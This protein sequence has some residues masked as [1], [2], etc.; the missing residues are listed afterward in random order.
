MNHLNRFST[1][2]K[3]NYRQERS[4]TPVNTINKLSPGQTCGDLNAQHHQPTLVS[5]SLNSFMN[6]VRISLTGSI[7][8]V[9]HWTPGFRD[10]RKTIPH[11]AKPLDVHWL[12]F[13]LCSHSRGDREGGHL[14][15]AGR[16]LSER[17]RERK[18][19][20][21]W[22][23]WHQETVRHPI[24]VLSEDNE[25]GNDSETL[26]FRLCHC[27]PVAT[28]GGKTLSFFLEAISHSKY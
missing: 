17:E 26:C 5:Q 4:S 25:Q 6:A 22:G 21:V 23:G 13:H 19:K 2:P 24:C 18:Q 20:L 10:T 3:N 9:P 16:R 8:A 7:T 15:L 1:D 27:N 14:S 28:P 12:V 11:K